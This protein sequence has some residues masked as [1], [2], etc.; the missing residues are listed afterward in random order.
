MVSSARDDYGLVA[1]ERRL[2]AVTSLG[3]EEIEATMLQA[4]GY[5]WSDGDKK[6]R[7]CGRPVRVGGQVDAQEDG[8]DSAG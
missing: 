7:S 2:A 4:Q 3:L 5:S 8:G 6:L 1:G